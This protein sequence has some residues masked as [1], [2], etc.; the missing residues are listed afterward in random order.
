M[1]DIFETLLRSVAIGMR[2]VPLCEIAGTL[3]LGTAYCCSFEP[4]RT[5][6]RPK[7]CFTGNVPTLRRVIVFT[8]PVD[9]E[10]STSRTK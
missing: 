4:G 7:S 2:M 8:A 3:L 9:S 5:M 1:Q 10:T 6:R